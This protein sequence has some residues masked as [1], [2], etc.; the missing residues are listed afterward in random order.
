MIKNCFG[1]SKETFVE[2]KI[3]LYTVEE[4]NSNT[5]VSSE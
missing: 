2:N 5:E 1:V 3:K 4:E